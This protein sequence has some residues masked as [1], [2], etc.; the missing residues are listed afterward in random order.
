M[1]PDTEQELINQY[2]KKV[3]K[4][5]LLTPEEEKEV[6]RRAKEGD[7]E[8][9]RK[10]VES[11]L[12]FV[13]NIAK[14]YLGYGLPLSEL[15]AAGNHGLIEA[16]KRFDPDRGVK[17][18]SYAVWWIR[19]AIMQALS[20]QTGAV[21]IPLKQAHVINRIGSIYSRLFRELE[22]EP[23]PEEVAIEYSKEILSRE[24]EREL[25]RKPTKDEVEQR[26]KKEGFKISPEEV[27]KCLQVCRIPLSLDAPVGENEDTFFVDFLSQHGTADVEERI[28]NEVLE[29]EIGDMLDRLPEKE[30]R[31]IEL[32]FGLRGEEPRT[33]REIGDILNISRER[34]RQLETRALRK[35]RNMAMKRHLKDFLS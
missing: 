20:Q 13:I 32:R 12:R 3:A 17:F 26:F 34:V 19:Q 9:F 21:R 30:R 18:I 6:A 5:P 25:G 31:V 4:I 15:I 7:Q 35:L 29:K 27:E 24:L 8:A 22:R 11:N 33:L 28:I 16:A 2:L 23:T 10:L 1:I 14:Q